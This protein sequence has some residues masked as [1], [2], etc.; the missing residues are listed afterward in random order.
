MGAGGGDV[1]AFEVSTPSLTSSCIGGALVGLGST[2][3][4]SGVPY[5]APS[6]RLDFDEA[7]RFSNLDTSRA[8]PP[9]GG[10][11]CREFPADISPVSQLR[12]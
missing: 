3:A 8:S 11:A 7:P 1:A 2:R 4:R 6:L 5:V 9:W 10:G 12:L